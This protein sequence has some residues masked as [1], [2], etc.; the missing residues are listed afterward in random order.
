MLGNQEQESNLQIAAP[1][2]MPK[3]MK[4]LM[5][6]LEHFS[7]CKKNNKLAI[8]F[9]Y[10]VQNYSIEYPLPSRKLKSVNTVS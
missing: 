1:P 10:K 2:T 5:N 3:L 4:R 9:Q 8:N 6:N 7:A